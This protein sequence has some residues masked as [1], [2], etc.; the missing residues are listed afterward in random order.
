[1]LL[2]VFLYLSNMLF[3]K[4]PHKFVMNILVKDEAEVIEA[5]IRYHYS[6]GISHFNV[7]DNGSSDGTAR[8]LMALSE[9]IPINIISKPNE[10]YNQQKWMTELNFTA[11]RQGASIV[12]NNDADE[13]YLLK[14]NKSLHDLFSRF[15]S[16]VQVKRYNMLMTKGGRWHESQYL[17]KS[18]IAVDKSEQ[19]SLKSIS[20]P[21]VAIQGKV[22]TNPWGLKAVGGGN[23]TARHVAKKFTMRV[24]ENLY[25]VHYPIQSWDKFRR[26]IEQ[27]QQLLKKG[28]KMGVHYHRW[29]TLLSNGFL[30]EEYQSMVFSQ[31][32]IDVLEKIG[33]IEKDE[34]VPKILSYFA[35]T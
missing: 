10:K 20:M 15:D 23:H 21:L 8:I 26:N 29:V 34:S 13:F 14:E 19:L 24:E 30:E 12:F 17:V 1:M 11:R 31:P 27:R 4:Q 33:V 7:I 9:E 32:D 35:S 3:R 6:I 5:N 16:V 28:A 22:I 25:V 2:R 18:P